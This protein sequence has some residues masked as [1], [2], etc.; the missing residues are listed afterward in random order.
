VPLRKSHLLAV[1]SLAVSAFVAQADTFTYDFVSTTPGDPASFTYT[2]PVLISNETTFVPTACSA[3]AVSC[4]NVVISPTGF[5]F[6]LIRLTQP[7]PIR[8]ESLQIGV[9]ESLPIS[10]FE[11][12]V[13]TYNGVDGDLSMTVTDNTP[14]SSTPEPFTFV[15]LASG[16]AGTIRLIRRRL[17]PREQ[18]GVPSILISAETR[19]K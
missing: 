15:M 18:S 1:I 2:S 17:S 16:L 9:E 3:L 5:E 13:H 4:E 19:H 8:T 7:N 12:G 6:I 14:V 11:I 10:F